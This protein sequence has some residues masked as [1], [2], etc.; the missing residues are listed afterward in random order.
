MTPNLYIISGCNGAGK[1]TAS[2]TILP[3][4]LNC[5][6]FI[7]ADEIAKGL[8]PL[9][10][11]K[12][13]IAAGKIMLELLQK[14]VKNKADFAFETTLATKGLINTVK[15]AKRNGY[16]I[17]LLYFW[18]DSPE[19]A[20]QRVS[21]RVSQGG[22]D[23]PVDTIRRRYYSGIKNFFT[24][25]MVEAD[26]WMIINN[27]GQISEIIAEG[28]GGQI[29]KISNIRIFDQIKSQVSK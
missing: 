29:D 7:N 17:T 9:N 6:T 22:H 8:S 26:F 15:T 20:I 27:S 16:N 3:E 19:L 10:P 25:Y 14:N 12:A 28:T 23:I 21:S 18:L 5:D 24:L 13:R 11:E 2:F 4:M 1:T